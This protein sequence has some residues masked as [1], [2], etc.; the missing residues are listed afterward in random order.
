MMSFALWFVRSPKKCNV[1]LCQKVAFVLA[2][3]KPRLR[4]GQKTQT[5]TKKMHFLALIHK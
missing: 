1:H 2:C 5:R 4:L 3:F